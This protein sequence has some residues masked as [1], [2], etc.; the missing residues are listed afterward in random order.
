MI[1]CPKC[2]AD[3]MVTAIFCRSC[4]EKLDLDDI[5]PEDLGPEEQTALQ[6]MMHVAGR[7]VTL[8]ILTALALL[9][10]MLFLPVS[11]VGTGLLNEK[12][13]R[14]AEARFK[15]IQALAPRKSKTA[16]I[17]FTNEQATAAL[18]VALGL[19]S[20]EGGGRVPREVSIEFLQE[21]KVRLVLV[22]KLFG[23]LPMS[24]VVTGYAKLASTGDIQFE[25]SSASVGKLPLLLPALKKKIGVDPIQAL[26][27]GKAEFTNIEKFTTALRF[28]SGKVHVT[29]R[30]R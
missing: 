23:K 18:N 22:S 28:E 2:G 25:V 15:A 4:R 17:S 13:Q 11:V 20:S 10:V 6:K 19:P 7:I 24:T 8:V 12:E 30:R 27:T 3:N 9:L 26:M 29:L 14:G 16:T 21:G 5:K 1:T